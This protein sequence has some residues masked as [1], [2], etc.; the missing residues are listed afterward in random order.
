M[1]NIDFQDVV[2][3]LNHSRTTKIELRPT[4]ASDGK[5]SL[6]QATHKVHTAEYP[7]Q[8][9]Y[10]YSAASIADMRNAARELRP[11]EETHVVYPPSI[12]PR[13]I[14]RSEEIQELLRKT[15]SFWNSKEYL[16]S[17][18]RDEIQ[19]YLRKLADQRPGDYI[20][21]RVETPAGFSRRFPNPLLSFLTDP[22]MESESGKLGIVLAEP[23][24]GKTYMSRYLVAR[25]SAAGTGVVPLMVDSSQ[26]HTMPLE[27]QRSLLK[28]IVHSFRHFGAAI[29]W[30]EGYEEE[31]LRVTLKA[32]IFRIVFDG[33]DEYILRNA[34]AVQPID[35]LEGLTELAKTT[36]TRIV[37]TS[38]TSFW[39]TN[40]PEAEIQKFI[41]KHGALVFKIL[42]FDVPHARNYFERRLS[43]KKRIDKAVQTYATLRREN[44]EFVGRGFVLSLV[45]DL[46][47][48]TEDREGLGLGSA[49]G[50]HWLIEALCEREIVRQQLPFTAT[51]QIDIF[52]TFAVEVAEG[53]LANT[54]LLEIAMSLIRPA[55]DVS[56]RKAAIDK[57]KS[58]P[59]VER[60]PNKDIWKFK[61]EQIRILLLAEEIATGESAKSDRF[62]NK[63]KLDPGTWQDIAIMIV[64]IL[65][66]T[67]VEGKALP[68]LQH[69][70]RSLCPELRDEAAL[71]KS[72]QGPRLAGMIALTA[73]ERYLPR[74]ISHEDRKSLLSELCGGTAIIGVTFSGTIA[75]YDFS[76]TRFERC[77]FERVSWANCRF[78]AGTT[79]LYC[80]FIGGPP[81][82]QCTGMGSVRLEGSMLDPDAEAIF[83]SER[84]REG[85]RKY[86]SDDLKADIQSVLTKFIIKGGIGLRSVESRNLEKGSI[87]ASRYRSEIL[88]VL[89]SMVL[90]KHPIRS[91]GDAYNVRKEAADAL[92]FY[93][94]NNVFTGVLREAFE[95][96]EKKL[97]L[98]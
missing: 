28:T 76:N 77:R 39:N 31:F 87:S 81:P 7:F 26:W 25:M 97:N 16:L 55:L 50:M 1:Q 71:I 49:E 30:L 92:K 75:R 15:K 83:N 17:Y 65:R 2:E 94:A 10:L 43:D 27:D 5:W 82:E 63:A 40:L 18:I 59:L 73:V 61:Q 21:P 41:D 64:D 62:V 47:D 44:E 96:L 58:H 48:Q 70:I 84:V 35:V 57:L 32:D 90:E 24:Q 14:R 54:E 52:R 12:D 80:V 42:P 37:I 74:G 88:D 36:G 68:K 56:S 46:A 13:Q 33:F 34:G 79:F 45:A 22:E 51:E 72:H 91:I 86:S 98:P 8:I 66:K 53:S 69:L 67:L 9:L 78:D 93:A 29:G 19:T 89:T 3:L 23:G 85:K 95:K 38:R 11:D 60:E 20:D 6:Y 4:K